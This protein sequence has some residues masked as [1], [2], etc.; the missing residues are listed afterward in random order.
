MK[1][2]WQAVGI[3]LVSGMVS[4]GDVP[5]SLD[6]V[7]VERPD[8]AT[9]VRF[10]DGVK[11]ALQIPLDRVQRVNNRIEVDRNIELTG[12][13]TDVTYELGVQEGYRGYMKALQDRLVNDG[14]EL[15]WACESRA[16]G[17]SGLWANTLFEVRELYGPNGNQVYF[18]V[19]LPDSEAVLTAY[20]IEQG[21]R[22]QYVHLRLVE[23][24]VDRR[25]FEGA[26]QLLAEGRV[27]LPVLFAGS[28]VSPESR[29][30]LND[31]AENL[32]TLVSGDLAIVAY[33]AV[34]PGGTLED[35]IRQSTARA[36]HVQSLLAEA[37]LSISTA[38]GLGALV[39][40][41][42][43]SSERVEIIKYR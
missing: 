22:R 31:V 26:K 11:T 24:N 32:A 2:S 13:V 40:S 33:T 14:A 38:H 35:A 27:V 30:V 3:W 42:K 10:S 16:C 7:M 15:L 20:G 29:S 39:P 28:R 12:F 4:A 6:L 25:S 36:E 18:A 19:K 43:L 41:R 8:G 23:P 34:T 17:V 9:I 1:W 21:N 37:G 5:G